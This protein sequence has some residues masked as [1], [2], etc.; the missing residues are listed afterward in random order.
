[1]P[2]ATSVKGASQS[3]PSQKHGI[4][5]NTLD[6][7]ARRSGANSLSTCLSIQAPRLPAGDRIREKS[8]W[9]VSGRRSSWDG[10]GFARRHT[11]TTVSRASSASSRLQSHEKLSTVITLEVSERA[12]SLSPS[13]LPFQI[14]PGLRRADHKL[15]RCLGHSRQQ[16]ALR[17]ALPVQVDPLGCI[18]L[19]SG[20]TATF[21]V[22]L[23]A[24]RWASQLQHL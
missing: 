15:L 7:F 23:C 13:N 4:A 19:L 11:F 21:G 3:Y 14:S 5:N 20:S 1:M 6:C 8:R 9:P 12:S 17:L 18:C 10:V 16:G 2:S 22:R 24:R